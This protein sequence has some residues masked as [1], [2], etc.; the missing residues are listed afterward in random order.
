MILYNAPKY[1][2]VHYLKWTLIV[3]ILAIIGLIFYFALDAIGAFND[4]KKPANNRG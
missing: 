2:W 1:D 4:P 3:L